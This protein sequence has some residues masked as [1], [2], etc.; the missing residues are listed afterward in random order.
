M[1]RQREAN[2]ILDALDDILTELKKIT[3]NTTP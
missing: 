2:P 1:S 3:R